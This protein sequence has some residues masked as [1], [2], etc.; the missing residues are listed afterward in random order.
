MSWS[1]KV[2]EEER[3]LYSFEVPEKYLKASTGGD[4]VSFH[5]V[6]VNEEWNGKIKF[7][8]RRDEAG[9]EL[10]P[11]CVG[12]ACYAA[13]RPNYSKYTITCVP[14]RRS[15]NPIITLE[16]ATHF[17]QILT[18]YGIIPEK[19]VELREE[20]DPAWGKGITC[21]IQAGHT[22][23]Q[24]IYATLASYRWID[25]HPSLVWEFLKIYAAGLGLSAFQ[26][27]PYL[28]AK[29]VRNC[30]HSFINSCDSTS[31]YDGGL[32]AYNRNPLVGVATKIFFDAADKR[33]ISF[34][35]EE[36][37]VNSTIAGIAKELLEQEDA[38]SPRGASYKL[39]Y[40]VSV[41][42]DT[43][44]PKFKPLYEI[45]NITKQQ[46]SEILSKL[47]TEGK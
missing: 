2:P 15:K 14:Y 45:P 16:E 6:G 30:N 18:R 22:S 44:H 19:G 8:Q 13:M 43:L 9:K 10:F 39:V 25:A 41:P 12:A 42:E 27:L 23:D 35:K 37:Y 34:T 17:F 28:I 38:K 5:A 46:A 36:T 26:I 29:Y 31:F 40:E 21:H 4:Y 7:Y 3:K 11:S 24:Q 33:G 32:A 47:F 1:F 20:S